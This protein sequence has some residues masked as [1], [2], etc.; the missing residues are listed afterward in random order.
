[1]TTT[2]YSP[3]QEHE[4][5]WQMLGHL[6]A[7]LPEVPPT[8][9]ALEALM[10]R[11]DSDAPS[12]SRFAQDR[13]PRVGRRNR[14]L[15]S[16]SGLVAAALAFFIFLSSTVEVVV[17]SGEFRTVTLKDGTLVEMNS[18]STLTYPRSLGY[19]PALFPERR[20]SLTGEAYFEVAH[21]G[22]PFYVTTEN[23]EINV[24][25]T[26]FNVRA[27]T[28]QG[29]ME[30]RVSLVSGKV[31]FY[32]LEKSDDEATLSEPGASA[33][34]TSSQTAEGRLQSESQNL[35]HV[36]AWR[37]RGLWQSNQPIERVLDELAI[38][39][40]VTLSTEGGL[41]VSAPI[42]L[43]YG[44]LPDIEVVLNEICLGTACNFRKTST[45]YVLYPAEM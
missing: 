35:S 19:W 25:G 12:E 15:W 4:E 27:R 14:I 31:K 5:A 2:K 43:Q 38:R 23:A 34:V 1:M 33:W 18:A 40:N 30:T 21:Q 39:Y 32:A 29:T 8:Q 11:I 13:K 26:E 24:L 28:H 41:D 6:K 3:N 36:L 10:R 22:T 42:T 45:G 44:E 17:P 16:G 7:E 37:D 9:E 20:V